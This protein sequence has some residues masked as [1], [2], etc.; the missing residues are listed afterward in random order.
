[1][2]KDKITEIQNIY[3]KFHQEFYSQ[4]FIAIRDALK[5]ISLKNRNQ[6]DFFHDLGKFV[7]FYSLPTVNPK[8]V[9]I[10]NNPSWFHESNSTLA[11]ENLDD[12]AEKIPTI[13][14]YK[15]HGHKFGNDL[16]NIFDSIGREY[17]TDEIVGLNRFWIQTGGK[18]TKELKKE[19]NKNGKLDVYKDIK[20]LCEK[21]TKDLVEILNPKLII[22][23][24]KPAQNIYK[25]NINK[26]SYKPNDSEVSFIFALHPS[27]P[28]KD[29]WKQTADDIYTFLDDNE[30][31]Y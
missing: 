12:V 5:R 8:V 17:W 25:P 24:G 10:G 28:E 20:N 14:S 6:R 9:I 27:Y 2:E 21:Y 30:I 26:S 13:N 23:L 19:C 31:N 18:G 11:K 4:K 29:A 1:M 16:N 3:D 15:V 7:I 22:L